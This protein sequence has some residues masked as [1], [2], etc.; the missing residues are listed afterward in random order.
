[1]TP[2]CSR[3]GTVLYGARRGM[4]ADPEGNAV[5]LVEALGPFA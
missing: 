4:T 5:E 1:L 3:S 2:S